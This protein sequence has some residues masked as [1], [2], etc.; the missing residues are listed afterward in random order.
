MTGLET[1]QSSLDLS[2]SACISFNIFLVAKLAALHQFSV[3]SINP[4]GQAVHGRCCP[5]R[6]LDSLQ[7]SVYCSSVQQHPLGGQL[8]AS[9]ESGQT[10]RK[11]ASSCWEGPAKVLTVK[12]WARQ[13]SASRAADV[14]HL[15]RLL[16]DKLQLLLQLSCLL[17]GS[18]YHIRLGIL[19]EFL[20]LEAPLQALQLLAD[21]VSLLLETL[22]L[23]GRIKQPCSRASQLSM[24]CTTCALHSDRSPSS[25]GH[26]SAVLQP[27]KAVRAEL[28]RQQEIAWSLPQQA[29][30]TTVSCLASSAQCP[31]LSKRG[32]SAPRQSSKA[33]MS[34]CRICCASHALPFCFCSA[35]ADLCARHHAEHR[36]GKANKPCLPWASGPAGPPAPRLQ[37]GQT[38]H[39]HQPLHPPC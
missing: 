28:S 3:I 23:L 18:C 11:G 29:T 37:S 35:Q 15:L 16:L 9:L 4:A 6:G 21:P 2:R 1:P 14:G 22:Q 5:G 33:V 32:S 24:L 30:P 36:K 39:W 7:K 19:Q 26:S 13:T 25:A 17:L 20:I 38:P 10:R 31:E 34:A 27:L 8:E 12:N